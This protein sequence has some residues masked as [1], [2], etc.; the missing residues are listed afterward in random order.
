MKTL[1]GLTWQNPRGERPLLASAREFA[2]KRSGVS[3]E[4]QAKP[5][6]AFEEALM[7]ALSNPGQDYDLVMFD[8]PWT[9]SLAASGALH[10]WDEL[11]P[12]EELLEVRSRTVAPSYDSYN[13][14]ERQW[15]IPL[16][17]ACHAGLFRCDLVEAKDLPRSWDTVAIWAARQRKTGLR[18]PLVLSVEGVLG[19]CLFLSMMASLGH[20]IDVREGGVR[21][22]RDA[23]AKVLKTILELLDF[24]PPGSTHWGPWDIYDYLCESDDTA[25]SPSIFAYVNYFSSEGRGN[26]LR[27]WETPGFATKRST[28]ILG[29]VGLG[30]LKKCKHTDLATEYAR[31]LISD[32][33]QAHLFPSNSGQPAGLAAWEDPELDQEFN[34]FYSALADEMAHAYTRPRMPGFH[35]L[36]LEIGRILQLCWDDEVTASATIERLSEIKSECYA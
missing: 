12:A 25:Y 24:T 15:G 18:H 16:D 23:A 1:T 34:G 13:W 31:Y 27:L 35:W 2:A 21:L 22:D 30:I 11:M 7:S 29:G 4:W 3:I 9:G 6:Y 8:H 20:P 10:P 14:N 5:W 19:S 17:A 33:V 28:P 32:Q 36:E 26:A